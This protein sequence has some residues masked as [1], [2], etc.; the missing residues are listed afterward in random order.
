MDRNKIFND[1]EAV[2]EFLSRDRRLHDQWND[3]SD[4]DTIIDPETNKEMEIIMLGSDECFDVDEFYQYVIDEKGHIYK[5][6]YNY[7]DENGN[8]LDDLGDIDYDRPYRIED[9]TGLFTW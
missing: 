8:Q 6:F 7:I 3:S 1:S 4:S 2:Q 5:A 9:I